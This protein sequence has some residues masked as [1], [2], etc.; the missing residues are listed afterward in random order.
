VNT[1]YCRNGLTPTK[2]DVASS[3]FFH[4]FIYDP[5]L[6]SLAILMFLFFFYL[7]C[8]LASIFV[9]SGQF[10]EQSGMVSALIKYGNDGG[11]RTKQMNAADLEFALQH[12][13]P[14][15]MELF[16]YRHPN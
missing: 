3:V 2:Q 11:R 5:I 14:E 1:P 8:A 15:L 10:K 6:L 13:D 7:P 12:L 9:L 4:L 16:Q